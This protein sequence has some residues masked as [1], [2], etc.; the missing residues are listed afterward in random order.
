M[1]FQAHNETKK[2][3]NRLFKEKGYKLKEKKVCTRY[4]IRICT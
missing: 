3:M 4:S 2:V 1:F